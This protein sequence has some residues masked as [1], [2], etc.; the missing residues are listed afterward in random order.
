MS[1]LA[2][3]SALRIGLVLAIGFAGAAVAMAQTTPAQTS[4]R[5][6]RGLFGG[7]SSGTERDPLALSLTVTEAYD[8]NLLGEVTS[9]PSVYQLGGRFTQLSAG[10]RFLGSGRKVQFSSTAGTNLRYYDQQDVLVGIG[11]YAGAGISVILSPKTSFSANQTISYAP[12][13][14]YRLFA[15]AGAPELGQVNPGTDYAVNN[16]PSLSSGTNVSMT[17]KLGRR[18]ELSLQA[19]G[20]YTDYVRD[21]NIPTTSVINGTALSDLL[22]YQVGGTFSQ[23][24]SSDLRLNLG[25]N[26]SRARYFSGGIPSEH[27]VNVGVTY[28]RPISKTRRANVGFNI[29]SSVLQ[30]EALGDPVGV[31]RQYYRVVGDVTLSRQF[32]RTWQAGGGYHRGVGFVEGIRTPVLTDAVVGGASG[33]INRRIDMSLNAAST[34]GEP[35]A[36]GVLS[37][38]RTNTASARSQ[39]ALNHHAAAYAEYTYYFYDFPAGLAPIA[40]PP[41][42]SRNSVRGG[43]ILWVPVRTK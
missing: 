39:M 26:F 25:Y 23:H 11:Q 8:Q 20:E 37:T 16:S 35:T 43:L 42:V 10:V 33:M 41:R 27:D 5:S 3:S 40:A 18:S 29:G 17:M 4:S 38:F 2:G 24:I 12:S 13:Y 31:L 19:R 34:V 1:A 7:A 15:T 30:R 36:I 9:A 6:Y 28:D 14:L 32:G 21:S 22:S